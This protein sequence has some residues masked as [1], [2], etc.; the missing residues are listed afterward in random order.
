ME[1]FSKS[2]DLALVVAVVST[3]DVW[4]AGME[5]VIR[6]GG[7]TFAGRW[8]C[9]REAFSQSGTPSAS[10]EFDL[11]I[12]ACQML[13]RPDSA[14]LFKPF[15]SSYSGRLIVAI[16]PGD[17]FSMQDFLLLDVEGLI[18]TTASLE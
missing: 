2:S 7:W 10:T 17:A 15:R 9:S 8:R 1:Y 6:H 3:F 4:C 13:D 18:L 5:H 14:I 16:A 12:I 11:A